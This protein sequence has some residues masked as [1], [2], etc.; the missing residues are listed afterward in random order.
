VRPQDTGNADYVRFSVVDRP[1]RRSP[2]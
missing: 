2:N 1:T